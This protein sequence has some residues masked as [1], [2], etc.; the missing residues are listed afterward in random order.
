[1]LKFGEVKYPLDVGGP[2]TL[3]ELERYEVRSPSDIIILSITE[4]V[5][6]L[7]HP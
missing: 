6:H 1:M 2:D 4:S 7:P 5:E 3:P